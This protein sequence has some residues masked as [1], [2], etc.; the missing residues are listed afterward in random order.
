MA[1][2]IGYDYKKLGRIDLMR[3]DFEAM[4]E[5]GLSEEEMGSILVA[6]CKSIWC[7]IDTVFKDNGTMDGLYKRTQGNTKLRAEDFIKNRSKN[8][9]NFI[10]PTPIERTTQYIVSKKHTTVLTMDKHE[11]LVKDIVELVLCSKESNYRDVLPNKQITENLNV[12]RPH[13]ESIYGLSYDELRD[14]MRIVY[15]VYTGKEPYEGFEETKQSQTNEASGTTK[16]EKE[17]SRYEEYIVKQTLTG[18]KVG[19]MPR[20]MFEA[21]LKPFGTFEDAM[22]SPVVKDWIERSTDWGIGKLAIK[23]YYEHIGVL[24]RTEQKPET[25]VA[26]SITED[27]VNKIMTNYYIV[28]GNETI[29]INSDMANYYTK[30]EIDDLIANVEGG[31]VDLTKY[32]TKS[33]IDIKLNGY[34]QDDVLGS[35]YTKNEVNDLLDNVTTGETNVDLSEYITETE[36]NAKGYLT[37]HQ[38]LDNYYTKSEVNTLINNIDIPTGNTNVNLNDY[39]TK[40]EIDE[41]MLSNH[42]SDISF[43]DGKLIGI[44]INGNTRN[45]IEVA[46]IN[47][48][49]ILGVNKD[50]TIPIVNTSD[51]YTKTEVNTLINNIDIPTG[52]TNVDMS[53]YYTKTEVNNL[54]PT[55]YIKTIPSE[56]ITETELNTSLNGY[57]T[58][59]HTHSEYI[60]EQY[61]DTALANR[62]TALETELSGVTQTITE[63]NNMVV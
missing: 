30:D 10:P 38:S 63:L 58:T 54:I 2:R 19:V 14:K 44:N 59:S 28:T 1:R 26:K 5:V 55:D 41:V 3:S 48:E 32:Y 33:Q 61:D 42:L 35:Y 15:N 52:G 43:Y 22:D 34:V 31:E 20:S 51:Y 16:Q 53:N 56:Y 45:E 29:D 25:V 8:P 47:G 49:R 21:S 62:I 18:E 11:A 40:S 46:T 60:T 23:Y 57:S 6:V 50:I 24:K 36:L 37:E 9:E 17:K 4:Q 39:Y 27:T 13:F 12:Q 7:D